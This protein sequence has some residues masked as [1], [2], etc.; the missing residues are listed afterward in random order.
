MRFYD[1]LF[2]CISYL[3]QEYYIPSH[4]TLFDLTFSGSVYSS[5]KALQVL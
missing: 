2:V 4:F 3:L 1:L 5:C